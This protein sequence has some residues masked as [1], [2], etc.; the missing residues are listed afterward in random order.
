MVIIPGNVPEYLDK[1]RRLEADVLVFDIQ[2]A[3]AKLDAAKLQAREMTVNAIAAGGFRAGEVCVR[4]NSPASPWF[5][6]DIKAV[7]DAGA[8]SIM[9][10]HAYSASDVTLV[11]GCIYT[12]GPARKVAIVIEVN[13]HGILAD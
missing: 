1:C 10:S 6:E 9:L 7:A 13:I 3:I 8:D 12:C 5:V 2:D 4:V 11:G